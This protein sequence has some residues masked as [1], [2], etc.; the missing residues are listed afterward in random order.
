MRVNEPRLALWH[1]PNV[2][3]VPERC[4]AELDVVHGRANE[5]G[6]QRRHG[7]QEEL[8]RAFRLDQLEEPLALV[9]LQ[10]GDRVAHDDALLKRVHDRQG[11]MPQQTAVHAHHW[12]ALDGDVRELDPLPVVAAC[13]G[14]RPEHSAEDVS[15]PELPAM[16]MEQ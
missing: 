3:P 1:F 10:E 7:V 8:I 9:V 2:V 12:G 11:H 15:F 14:R 4:D 13:F 6:I 16:S 5:Q